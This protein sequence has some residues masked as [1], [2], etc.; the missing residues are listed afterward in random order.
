MAGAPCGQR[1]TPSPGRVRS[2]RSHQTGRHSTMTSTRST[3]RRLT[4]IP[5]ATI[6]AAFATLALASA[7]CGSSGG[8]ADGGTDATTA[9]AVGGS[10]QLVLAVNGLPAGTTPMVRVAGGGLAT[11]MVLAVGTPVTLDAGGGY[12]IDYRRVKMAPAAG[13]IIG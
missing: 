12:E 9:C 13:G 11:P 3:W 1:C 10:G 8:A 6:L 5:L 2:R 4:T 7:G